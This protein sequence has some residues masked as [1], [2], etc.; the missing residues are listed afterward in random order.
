MFKKSLIL[1]L[2]A[3][4]AIA[5]TA[6]AGEQIQGNTENTNINA[7]NVGKGNRIRIINRTYVIQSQGRRA[8]KLLCQAPSN[9]TQGNATNTAINATNIGNRNRIKINNVTNVVQDQSTN[10][11]K[12]KK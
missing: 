10:C 12:N 1:G 9:Q 5:P 11:S 7:T 2:L 3:A 4:M 6:F 8:R